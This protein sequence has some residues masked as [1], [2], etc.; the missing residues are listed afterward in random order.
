MQKSAKNWILG[1]TSS[2]VA[3]LVVAYTATKDGWESTLRLISAFS[4]NLPD[5]LGFF[6]QDLKV[7]MWIILLWTL[8]TVIGLGYLFLS[9]L[10]KYSS[11]SF[12]E[13]V[14]EGL[15]W[16]WE[17]YLDD[18]VGLNSYCLSCDAELA[19]DD[20]FWSHSKQSYSTIFYCPNRGCS[21]EEVGEVLGKEDEVHDYITKEIKRLARRKAAGRI[22]FK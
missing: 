18:P 16:R 22:K 14:I 12:K 5:F 17:W 13:A 2:L 19:Q 8:I 7:P 6:L 4:Q 10:R 1:G 3:G 9:M 15:K 11:N 20:G 21:E